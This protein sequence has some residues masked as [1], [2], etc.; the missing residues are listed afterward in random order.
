[1]YRKR[2][3]AG[4]VR[5][6]ETVARRSYEIAWIVHLRAVSSRSAEKVLH[7]VAALLGPVTINPHLSVDERNP[8]I[9]EA[10]FIV[11]WEVDSLD[12]RAAVGA[13][14]SVA[15]RV[16]TPWL[17]FP[18]EADTNTVAIFGGITVEGSKFSVA[19]VTFAEFTLLNPGDKEAVRD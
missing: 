5:K 11:P 4:R 16:A 19:G 15:A 17:V 9:I 7:R 14:L 3:L 13:A 12:T 1:V 6:V 8:K 2:P 10:A 18:P